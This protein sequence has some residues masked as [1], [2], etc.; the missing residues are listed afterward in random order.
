M[1]RHRSPLLAALSVAV[2]TAGG[3]S[4]PIQAGGAPGSTYTVRLSGRRVTAILPSYSAII[5]GA[6]PFGLRSLRLHGQP[7]DFVHPDLVAGDWEWFW[8]QQRPGAA[9]Q[10]SVKLLTADWGAPTVEEGPSGV[11]VT[12]RLQDIPTPG[13]ELS[14][15]FELWASGPYLEA[16]YTVRNRSPRAVTAPY[17]M[18]GFPGFAEGGRVVEVA[19]ARQRRV[20]S[21]PHSTF[22]EEAAALGRPEYLLLRDDVDPRTASRGLRSEVRLEAGGL[23]YVI[24]AYCFRP[25]ASLSRIYSA[26]TNKPQYLTSHLYA[27]FADL[28]PGQSRS[29][30]VLYWLYADRP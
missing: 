16:A 26:H 25:A 13:L 14:A 27:T 30:N 19:D 2:L 9:G 18:V 15:R 21:Q 6:P 22:G 23:D 12:Y 3:L 10:T 4:V 29:L 11:S 17:V 24:R 1:R 8:Y 20:P 28:P 7:M 5:D